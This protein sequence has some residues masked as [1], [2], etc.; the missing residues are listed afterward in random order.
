MFCICWYYGVNF[1][2]LVNN[3]PTDSMLV[4]IYLF[5]Y[6]ICIK[7]YLYNKQNGIPIQ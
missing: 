4:N 5:I 3:S 7:I 6:I 2:I 1:I